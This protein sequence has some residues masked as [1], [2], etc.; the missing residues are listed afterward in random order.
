MLCQDI[1]TM[2]R[3]RLREAAAYAGVEYSQTAIA[4]SLG[5]SK[6]TVDGWF[7]G[8]EP[9]LALV[10]TIAE[11][12]RVNPTWL[13]TGQ[14][15]MIQAASSGTPLSNEE[16]AII[17]SFRRG[18]PELK[19]LLLQ[20][21]KGVGKALV[22]FALAW[23]ISPPNDA[24]ASVFSANARPVYYVK[25]CGRLLRQV[26]LTLILFSCRIAKPHTS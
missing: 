5:I 2:F 19:R 9:R 22:L 7:A 3:D 4:R 14:G 17:R 26:F 18:S 25:R 21:A 20:L 23:P 12:W 13:A 15:D 16:R 10:G 24:Q 1:R 11:R 6:Q 8:G